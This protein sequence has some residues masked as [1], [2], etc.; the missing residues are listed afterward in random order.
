M[1]RAFVAL[2][3][4]ASAFAAPASAASLSEDVWNSVVSDCLDQAEKE[5]PDLFKGDGAKF[6]L[7]KGENGPS[8][9]VPI[10]VFNACNACLAKKV[11]ADFSA[12]EA[13]AFERGATT[14]GMVPADLLERIGKMRR[15]CIQ[16]PD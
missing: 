5:F 15:E 1:I 12:G 4:L 16:N 7:S 14:D 10:K 6:A 11:D 3:V 13:V 2:I 8:K 9:D